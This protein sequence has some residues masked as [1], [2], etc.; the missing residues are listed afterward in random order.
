MT[1]YESL[2]K[3]IEGKRAV[4]QADVDACDTALAALKRIMEPGLPFTEPATPA[5][6]NTRTD[7]TPT[8]R[9]RKT[10]PA[11]GKPFA[12][13]SPVI[14]RP[15]P[16][17]GPGPRPVRPYVRKTAGP[18]PVVARPSTD[19]ASID[20]VKK[21]VMAFL[22]KAWAEPTD[23]GGDIVT[24]ADG[25]Q[26]RNHVI[27]TLKGDKDDAAFRQQIANAMTDLKR[28]GFIDRKGTWWTLTESG[29]ER[30]KQN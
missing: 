20:T 28:A 29:R 7:A 15:S 22:L 13:P 12:G 27:K 8:R 18:A 4:A 19:K 30:A 14:G 9:T 16:V 6:S 24:G 1:S 17:I 23:G 3:E 5:A 11:K 2:K 26:I 10:W 21:L 25:S